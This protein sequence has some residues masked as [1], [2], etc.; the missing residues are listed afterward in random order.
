VSSAPDIKRLLGKAKALELRPRVPFLGVA[1]AAIGG[2]TAAERW[3]VDSAVFV[4]ATLG[5]GLLALVFR[6]NSASLACAFFAFAALHSLR[7]NENSGR[8]LETLVANG[9]RA[10]EATGVVWSEPEPLPYSSG[11][12]GGAFELKLT[13]L[14]IGGTSIENPALLAVT[15]AGPLPHYGDLVSIA[16]A[17]KPLAIPRNPGQF[18]YAN[19][20]R[21]QGIFGRLEAKF[22][23]DCRI[24][25]HDRGNRVVA[26]AIR[27]RAWMQAQLGRDLEDSPEQIALVSS[28]VLGM[29]GE[30]PDEVQDLFRQTGTLHL[31]AV[32]GLNIAMLAIIAGFVLQ[33]FG[34][35]HRLVALIIIPILVFYAVITGLSASCVRAALMGAFLMFALVAE[36]KACVYNSLCAA[37]VLIL[38]WDTNQFFAPGFQFSFVLVLTIVACANRIQKWVQPLGMPDPFL[39]RPLWNWR[40]HS[41]AFTAKWLAASLGVTIASWFGSLA[42]TAGYF[43]MFSPSAVVANMIAVPIAFL[44][45]AL[46][47]ATLL[48]APISSGVASLFTNANW[49]CAK[50]LLLS[51][52]F[53][54]QLPGSHVYV[55]L[56]RLEARPSFELTV[57]DVGD[58]AAIHL[59]NGS[60]EWLVDGGP[61]WRYP[62]VTLPYLRSRGVNRLDGLFLTHGDAQ[63]LGSAASLLADLRPRQVF[64][65]PVKTARPRARDCTRN[66]AR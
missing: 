24:I 63:H 43:H 54:A 42:F 47:L 58:G 30:T 8:A 32:S 11:K 5:V 50:A 55:E 56:P 60:G 14:E 33:P 7:H 21:R 12:A 13:R 31:F 62:N 61:A 35:N 17:L 37:A 6:R 19:Y 45:L 38:A 22:A 1:I 49:F 57:L 16:G 48:A 36:R 44:V 66:S 64:D 20:L 40:Q 26:L 65:T 59:R 34:L 10:V 3:K 53:F 15:W 51:V 23:E 2:I 29:R 39:P 18:D 25:A 52:K 9:P 28:M 46:G 27:T 4:A 41:R